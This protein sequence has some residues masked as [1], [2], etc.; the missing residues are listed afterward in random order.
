MEVI[1]LTSEYFA[2]QDNN[3]EQLERRINYIKQFVNSDGAPIK[4]INQGIIPLAE[5]RLNEAEKLAKNMDILPKEITNGITPNMPEPDTPKPN[6]PEPSIP[7]PFEEIQPEEEL[8]IPKTEVVKKVYQDISSDIGASL[9]APTELNEY[10][11]RIKIPAHER[12]HIIRAIAKALVH[13]RKINYAFFR[14][15]WTPIHDG[16]HKLIVRGGVAKVS[17]DGPIVDIKV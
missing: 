17:I 9:Q 4:L 13:R 2:I 5:R 1:A 16:Y 3:Q 8:T 14:L 6:T 11:A 12:G 10:E 15:D 7:K